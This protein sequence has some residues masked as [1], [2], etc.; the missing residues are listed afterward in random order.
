MDGRTKGYASERGSREKVKGK[1]AMGTHR[2]IVIELK[3]QNVESDIS[4]KSDISGICNCEE[5]IQH[6][7]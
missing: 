4:G 2:D 5:A 7:I 3:K 1:C 6:C